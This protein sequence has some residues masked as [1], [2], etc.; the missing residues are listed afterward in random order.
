MI[1]SVMEGLCA[2]TPGKRRVPTLALLVTLTVAGCALVRGTAYASPIVAPVR[3][4]PKPIAQIFGNGKYNRNAFL[5]NSVVS[6]SAVQAIRNANAG[7]KVI[8]T[9]GLCKMKLHCRIIQRSVLDP[10]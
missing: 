10:W 1:R 4:H 2:E 3:N 8:N 7:G 5:V 6:D 9:Q